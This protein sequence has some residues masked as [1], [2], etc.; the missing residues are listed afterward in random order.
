MPKL[1]FSGRSAA[2]ISHIRLPL[3]A[4]IPE[5]GDVEFHRPEGEHW[6]IVGGTLDALKALG[7][8]LAGK[9][10]C[11][12]AA[13]PR[14]ADG[15]QDSTVSHP[16]M[17]LPAF[18][19]IE[20]LLAYDGSI[21]VIVDEK[22]LFAI[23]LLMDEVFRQS[24]HLATFVWDPE[25]GDSE[26]C[27]RSVRYAIAFRKS[28]VFEANTLVPTE[29]QRGRYINHD[30][31]DRGP[32]KAM[33]Y[34]C[35]YTREERPG[36]YYAIT[37]PN[38]GASVLPSES[39]VWAHA[40]ETHQRNEEKRLVW[41][42]ADG[43]NAV[44]A[45]KRFLADGLERK[46]ATVLSPAE[47]LDGRHAEGADQHAQSITP[48]GLMQHLLRIFLADDDVVLIPFSDG[49]AS[50]R[51]VEHLNERD[52]GSR[53]YVEIIAPEVIRESRGE[54]ATRSTRY[55]LS[56][57]V[58]VNSILSGAALPSFPTIARIA[59]QFIAG[60]TLDVV[61]ADS[62]LGYVGCTDSVRVHV[63]YRA[64]WDWLA[65]SAAALDMATVQA[66]AASAGGIRC[67]V[68]A[69][70]CLVPAEEL[71][72]LGVEFLHFPFAILPRAT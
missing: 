39:R 24:N 5:Q 49:S 64:D 58:A 34:T 59:F 52:G 66:A 33:D 11:V 72:R 13:M 10:D 12:V 47:V 63:L 65:S 23:K 1:D 56:E 35:R 18:R 2:A 7:P 71:R 29:D 9:V 60:R 17:A 54:V 51:A 31:D 55:G 48:D 3:R 4:L 14:G 32:W 37:N 27:N 21:L 20:R 16:A 30:A 69:P 6:S 44:P 57:P 46:A 42:G 26:R 67:V 25:G 62:P 68:V 70:Y 22:D 61:P 36:Q 15:E 40:P 53:R 41:W 43:S 50:V 19:L 45:K 28:A 38:T 8:V